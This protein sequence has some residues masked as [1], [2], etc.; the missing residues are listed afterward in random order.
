MGAKGIANPLNKVKNDPELEKDIVAEYLAGVRRGDS[1]R[2]H[3]ISDDR[4]AQILSKNGLNYAPVGAPAKYATLFVRGYSV[5]EIARVCG[6]SQAAVNNQLTQ[7]H[8]RQKYIKRAIKPLVLEEEK[9]DNLW[10]MLVCYCD[11]CGKEIRGGDSYCHVEMQDGAVALCKD[12]VQ[13]GMTVA[14]EGDW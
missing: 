5:P 6:V 8:A 2:I 11:K 4:Y 10:D 13:Y 12:C 3:H 9:L 1:R 7:T 14:T